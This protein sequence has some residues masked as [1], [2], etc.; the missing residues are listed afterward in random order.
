MS[1]PSNPV[2]WPR[3]V[4][5]QPSGERFP[6]AAGQS[7]IEAALLAGVNLPRSCRNGTC[8]ACIAKL[9]SGKVRYRIAWPGLSFDEHDEGWILPCVAEPESDLVISV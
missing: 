6:V 5:V 4:C 8:R 3:W 7:V 1:N 9:V 2:P